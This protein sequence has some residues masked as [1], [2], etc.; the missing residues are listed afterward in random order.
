MKKPQAPNSVEVSE[1]ALT[2][3]PVHLRTTPDGS[4]IC[5]VCGSIFEVGAESA[6]TKTGEFTARGLPIVRPSWGIC[7][8]CHTEFGND[9]T[10]NPGE[11]LE[12]VWAELRQKW[13]QQAPNK[14]DALKQLRE[15]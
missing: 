4:P 13:L 9:D 5:P 12:A 8:C 6:W 15:N 14:S 10:P 2:G 1:A 3:D 11:T 7:P